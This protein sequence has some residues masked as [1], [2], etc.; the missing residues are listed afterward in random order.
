M[1]VLAIDFG[2]ARIGLAIS[3]PEG[4]LAMP[5]RTL[6]RSSDNDARIAEIVTRED[7]EHL[8]IGEPRNMNGTLGDAAMRVRSF[9][10][11]LLAQIPLR[12]ALVDETLTS[13]AARER[14]RD[15]G[16]DPRRHPE[17]IDAVAAQILLEQFLATP[18][19]SEAVDG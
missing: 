10:R 7:V 13:V 14:L 5:L 3:D 4:K 1:K 6:S 16:V 8:V 17:R 19:H 12:C 18:D 11:K 2:E 9:T 15:A